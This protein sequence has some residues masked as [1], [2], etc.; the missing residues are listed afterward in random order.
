[1]ILRAIDTEPTL[2][3][4]NSFG[5]QCKRKKKAKKEFAPPRGLEPRTS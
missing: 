1:L 4:S 3:H 2:R 5:Q